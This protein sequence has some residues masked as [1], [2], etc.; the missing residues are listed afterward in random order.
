MASAR[1]VSPKCS[2]PDPTQP[3]LAPSAAT[4][5]SSETLC[6]LVRLI[7]TAIPPM[8]PKTMTQTIMPPTC[9]RAAAAAALLAP[10]ARDGAGRCRHPVVVNKVMVTEET[11][12]DWVLGQLENLRRRLERERGE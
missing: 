10:P 6:R 8:T 9:S 3:S 1:S 7:S 12:A 4:S 5:P 2:L 11:S